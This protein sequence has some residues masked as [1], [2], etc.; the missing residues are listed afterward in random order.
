MKESKNIHLLP[1]IFLNHFDTVFPMNQIDTTDNKRDEIA[2]NL[3]LV[4]IYR[5]P[6]KNHDSNIDK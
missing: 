5:I 1:C 4:F 6:K 3:V 2:A